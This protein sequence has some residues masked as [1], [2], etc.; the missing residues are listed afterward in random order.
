[1]IFLLVSTIMKREKI[2]A[3]VLLLPLIILTS[4]D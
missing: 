4:E 3:H 2:T 1:M